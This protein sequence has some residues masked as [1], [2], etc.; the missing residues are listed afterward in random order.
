M[1]RQ[2]IAALA[3]EHGLN[4]AQPMAILRASRSYTASQAGTIVR[5]GVRLAASTKVRILW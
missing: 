1:A 5:L 3:V 2:K 4:L